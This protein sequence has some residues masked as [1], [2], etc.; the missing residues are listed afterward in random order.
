M[1]SRMGSRPLPIIAG[2]AFT[3]PVGVS[4]LD[5][6]RGLFGLGTEIWRGTSVCGRWWDRWQEGKIPESE[7]VESVESLRVLPEG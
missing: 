3:R 6:W 1:K 5:F 2:T 7:G 4:A